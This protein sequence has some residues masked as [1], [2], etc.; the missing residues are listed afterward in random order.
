MR[1][2]RARYA[3]ALVSTPDHSIGSRYCIRSVVR[4]SASPRWLT[5][6][7]LPAGPCPSWSR[8]R[9]DA[10]DQREL[11]GR[12]PFNAASGVYSSWKCASAAV[13]A[14][15]DH[16]TED[17]PPRRGLLF[18]VAAIDRDD[19]ALA[20]VARDPEVD[21]RLREREVAVV[22]HL[23]VDEHL[24]G[25]IQHAQRDPTALPPSLYL[26]SEVT[27]SSPLSQLPQ[28]ALGRGR[29]SRPARAAAGTPKP[30]VSRFIR[31][32]LRAPQ[33]SRGSF[34]WRPI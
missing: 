10:K 7:G 23:A 9:T 33:S 3:A 18:N 22:A 13:V 19:V 31:S 20:P 6:R 27:V 34:G 14:S 28:I 21:F 24:A 8:R 29:P 17:R 32:F 26:P 5:T 15:P 30:I 16:G 11:N 2:G 25:L 4:G 12:G 1:G